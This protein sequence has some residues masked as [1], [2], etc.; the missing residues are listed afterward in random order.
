MF[1]RHVVA[2]VLFSFSFSAATAE[3]APLDPEQGKLWE[4]VMSLSGTACMIYPAIEDLDL[5]VNKVVRGILAAR[6]KAPDQLAQV[7]S[8][9]N[10][11]ASARRESMLGLGFVS[12]K[13]LY[14]RHLIYRVVDA[15]ETSCALPPAL[16]D[17]DECMDTTFHSILSSR[18]PHSRYLNEEEF[19]AERRDMMGE[20]VG[21]GV[22]IISTEDK[23]IGIVHVI[24]DSPA[25]KAGLLD[26]DRIVAIINDGERALVSSFANTNDAWKKLSG[27]PGTK[28]TLEIL[29]GTS[30]RFVT[31]TVV[32]DRIKI[33]MVKTSI[34]VD[35]ND[36]KTTYAYVKLMQFG[37]GIRE[38][39]VKKVNGLLS[40]NKSVKGIIFDVRGNPGGLLDE[41]YEV[42]DMLVES[43]DALV[44][45]RTNA[46]IHAYGTA[47]DERMPA[48]QPG[49]MTHG[50]PMVV[51]VDRGS[52]SAA[53]IFAGSLKET[54][55]AVII[56]KGTWQKGTVQSHIPL[57]DG[58]GVAI[59]QS[60]YLI[61]SPEK[62]VAVQCVGVVPDMLYEMEVFWKPKKEKR[63]C[64]LPDV[65]VSGGARSA[66][67]P[68]PEPLLLRDPLRYR[69]GEQMLDAVKV[70]DHENFLYSERIR[71]LLKI[72]PPKED[73]EDADQ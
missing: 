69:M 30:E 40:A 3:S 50:L 47:W 18:D 59:T 4:K 42:V 26:G 58:S 56:G 43:P 70:L 51:L 12:A 55:R 44:S 28:V 68:T 32:R 24:E 49:D 41:V 19:A 7:L 61:G 67:N 20:L 53:E 72:T 10:A 33:E 9:L 17:F 64:D 37:K 6:V 22:N 71:K 25:E 46:D 48:P 31:V 2:C 66:G 73:P 29:R 11:K 23:A 5:C 35:P 65:V 63:E 16:T 57:D 62:W 45:I 8:E 60:E 21:V 38:E 34:L 36:P 15:I 14:Q 27:K 39:M 52:A 54:G 1:L 13:E